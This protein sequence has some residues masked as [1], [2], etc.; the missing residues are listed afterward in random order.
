MVILDIRWNLS[1]RD[2]IAM[3]V[4][5][6]KHLLLCSLVSALSNAADLGITFE[7]DSQDSA[8]LKLDYGTYRGVYNATTDVSK[9]SGRF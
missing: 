9:W 7:N 6:C 8:L 4:R 2:K 1:T 5:V 3:M